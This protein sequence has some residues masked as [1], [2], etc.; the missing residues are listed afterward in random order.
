MVK[1]E[2]IESVIYKSIDT[3]KCRKEYYALIG[4][5]NQVKGAMNRFAKSTRNETIEHGVIIDGQGHTLVEVDGKENG[6][7]IPVRDTITKILEEEC[8]DILDAYQKEYEA[9]NSSEEFVPFSAQ[10]DMQTKYEKMINERIGNL[11]EQGILFNVD[12]NHPMLDYSM[13]TCLSSDDLNNCLSEVIIGANK[14]IGGFTLHNV[15][16]SITAECGN[17]TRMTIV[18]NNPMGQRTVSED[19]F[20]KARI[21]Q[22][23][24]WIIMQ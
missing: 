18:N 22:N 23:Y 1:R 8:K 20:N 14:G 16:K 11:N 7:R 6:V 19:K 2:L 4:L 21:L 15:I 5:S 12:H 17:G 3:I 24:S 13:F 10:L 9:L